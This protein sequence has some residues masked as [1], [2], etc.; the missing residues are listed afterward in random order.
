[1]PTRTTTLAVVVLAGLLPWL[2]TCGREAAPN[3]VAAYLEGAER[4]S[5]TDDQR[6]EI[7]RALQDML[8][9]DAKALAARRYA[10]YQ[11][12]PGRWTAIQVLERYFVPRTRTALDPATFY[13]DVKKAA[14]MEA[15]RKQLA[16]L[17]REPGAR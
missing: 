8:D 14:A 4:Q 12:R 2:P 13:E 7:R 16:A 11:L 6:R 10:D 9:L 17:D 15:V 3:A 1:M 5:E